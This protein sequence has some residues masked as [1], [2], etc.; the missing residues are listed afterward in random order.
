MKFWGKFLILKTRITACDYQWIIEK[1]IGSLNKKIIVAPV[2][3]H[4]VTL[5]YLKND[6]QK[7]L[8]KIDYVL[9]DSQWVRW[10]LSWLYGIKLPDRIYGPAL[11]IKLCK[12]AEKES[13]KICLIGNNLLNLELRLKNL[14]PNLKIVRLIEL[15]NKIID[16]KLTIEINKKTKNLKNT[17]IFIGIGSPN[18]HYLALNLKDNLPIICVGATFDFISG[19]KKQAPKWMGNCGLEWLF[20]LINE[21]RLWKRYLID[22]PLFL[23]FLFKQ[24]IMVKNNTKRILFYK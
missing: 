8:D 13:I 5:A 7:V 19:V 10:S 2:A 21:L 9:P 6:Y 24:I 4:P 11:F 3:S 23:I 22:S 20:R 17:I 1:I 16:K 12:K 15:D 18:Q 14:F